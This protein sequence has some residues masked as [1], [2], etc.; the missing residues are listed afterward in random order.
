[1]AIPAFNLDG[2]IPP[3]V[4]SDPG[5]SHRDMSPYS[6]T[7]L[8]FVD[9]FS[10]SILRCQILNGWL[11]HRA[12]LRALGVVRG[13]QWLD[14]SFVEKKDPK[15]LDVITFFRRPANVHSTQLAAFALLPEINRPSIKAK[16]NLDAFFVDLDGTPE[17]IVTAT[18]YYGSLFSH[19]RIDF[20]WKGMV[21][22]SL[23][24]NGGDAVAA[25]HLNSRLALLQTAQASP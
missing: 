4:G 17:A 20:L 1:M 16:Y 2:V 5:G 19:R 14:G 11:A 6:A 25:S 10:T 23:I 9:T 8:E 3:F 15:D 21:A 7:S 22:V 18:R 13:F 24:D 12:A